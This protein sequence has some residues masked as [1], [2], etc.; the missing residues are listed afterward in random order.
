MTYCLGILLN[1]GLVLSAD[2]RTNAGV[3]Q[4][5]TFR[6]VTVL[7]DAG[8]AAF[9]LLTAGNL[10]TSQA[11]INYLTRDAGRRESDI[12]LFDV[13]NMF[14]AAEIVGRVLRNVLRDNAE[15]VK[16]AHADPNAEFLIGG[17]IKGGRH[18]LFHVYSAG[19]FIEAAPETPFVQ[20]GE[21]KY[22]KPILDR[23]VEYDTP[24]RRA[25]K[26][27]LLSFDSTMR[28]NLSVGLPI[29]VVVYR[30]DSYRIDKQIE[31]TADDRYLQELR[32]GYGEGI[33]NLFDAL[34]D[35]KWN[36]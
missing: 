36:L 32:K 16:A 1:E 29:D 31:V 28:S 6:K 33:V 18:R 7:Q 21:T 10:A 25:V 12:N 24:T 17:Q 34:P 30:K 26:A 2:T 23:V 14:A 3:D 8:T 9:V 27:A 5:A 19:N 11:V 15:Y 35:P 20:I 22:G 4:I 13:P